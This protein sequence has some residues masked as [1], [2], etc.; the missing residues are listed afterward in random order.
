[1]PL[2]NATTHN[3]GFRCSV[4][5]VIN[6]EAWSPKY[7][8]RPDIMGNSTRAN[9]VTISYL[10][11]IPPTPSYFASATNWLNSPP[12][13]EFCRRSELY[14]TE[15]AYMP[16]RASDVCALRGLDGVNAKLTSVEVLH[17][18]HLVPSNVFEPKLACVGWNC[19]S[20][21][22]ARGMKLLL[23]VSDF[24]MT[25]WGKASAHK[26]GSSSLA[27]F[28]ATVSMDSS[29]CVSQ[30]KTLSQTHGVVMPQL[31][32]LSGCHG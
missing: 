22:G 7:R 31:W 10:L 17:T 4:K 11:S 2:T 5:R 14:Q 29:D 20:G 19:A 27:Y 12:C 26:P 16:A 9:L 1:M 23:A 25:L 15:C 3:T 32:M 24:V 30:S 8:P 6:G 18:D 13:S 21:M 28:R